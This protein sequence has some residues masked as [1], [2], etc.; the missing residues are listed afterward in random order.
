MPVK[1]QTV[2]VPLL[3]YMQSPCAL[4]MLQH[5]AQAGLSGSQ[6]SSFSAS[7]SLSDIVPNISIPWQ[8]LTPV[9]SPVD[10]YGKFGGAAQAGLFVIPRGAED[11]ELYATSG[12]TTQCFS[13][14]HMFDS[15]GNLLLCG[16]LP[17]FSGNVARYTDTP[18]SSDLYN[19]FRKTPE[20][21]AYMAENSGMSVPD[22]V[23]AYLA[24]HS[25][26]NFYIQEESLPGKRLPYSPSSPHSI[27]YQGM[28]FTWTGAGI[29]GVRQLSYRDNVE[30][31]VLTG[32]PVQWW[33]DQVSYLQA[34]G[35]TDRMMAFDYKRKANKC[36]WLTLPVATQSLVVLMYTSC[37]GYI[38]AKGKNLAS[39]PLRE[40]PLTP[41][42]CFRP[43]VW[44]VR[45]SRITLTDGLPTPP[46][47]Y[48]SPTV[49]PFRRVS[50]AGRLSQCQRRPASSHSSRLVQ[51]INAGISSKTQ[52]KKSENSNLKKVKKKSG[53]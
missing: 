30:D 36:E 3:D 25:I 20:I 46:I 23:K 13:T 10:M 43:K 1:L 52:V 45:D 41:V 32:N 50:S 47:T 11:V 53:E 35:T 42:D 38:F 8:R 19:L 26:P 40:G 5:E 28:R 48:Y 34:E 2:E 15:R 27:N 7:V 29:E 18:T 31:A 12:C 9:D 4:E 14:F 17:G 44:R 37:Y 51:R 21:T 6:D 33:S 16:G 49:A 39:H 22:A 24:I